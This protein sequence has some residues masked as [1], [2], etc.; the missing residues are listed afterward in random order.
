ME[1]AGKLIN[2]RMDDTKHRALAE[3]FAA[4]LPVQGHS[5]AAQQ[6]ALKRA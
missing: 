4:G 6:P 3:Q 5:P 1:V 2:E